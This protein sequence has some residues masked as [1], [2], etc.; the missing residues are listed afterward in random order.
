[1]G[2]SLGRDCTIATAL[3]NFASD[4]VFRLEAR[5]YRWT[6]GDGEIALGEMA[7]EASVPFTGVLSG[8]PRPGSVTIV[9]DISH[10]TSLLASL[11]AIQ[12]T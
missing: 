10:H 7:D 2:P 4:M 12:Y 1:M 5:T 11:L 9:L 6:I 8:P 3:L